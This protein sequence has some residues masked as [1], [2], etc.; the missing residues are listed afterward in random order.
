MQITS[1]APDDYKPS[2]ELLA[3]VNTSLLLQRPLL[4][5]GDPG[6]GK[7]E[8]A[9]FVAR[10][11]RASYPDKFKGTEAMRFNTKSVSQSTD[12]FYNYDA[13]AHFGD[14]EN[15]LKESFISFSSLGSALLCT[16]E[17]NKEWYKFCNYEA[18]VVN[19]NAG[20]GSV[21]LIDEIDKA[22]RD[23]PND[24][25]AELEKPPFKF[26][27]KELTGFEVVQSLAKPIVIII[28][29]NNEKGLPDAF[30][31]RC[32]FHHINFPDA[33]SLLEIVK[34]KL[35][36]ENPYFETAINIFLEMR[37]KKNINKP[38]AT[39]E[40]IDWITCLKENELLNTNLQNLKSAD[41]AYRKKITATLGII[42][43][44]KTD[45]ETL[46]K[47]IEGS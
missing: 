13:V 19:K 26:G 21:V 46:R 27:I 33:A 42:A 22:P 47:E 32:V 7:T 15:R 37:N 44:T 11:L 14:K 24:L 35:Q 28:T 23:F 16:L 1:I 20:F 4:L 34:T 31:R 8:C 6:T 18:A 3:A 10:Q 25:L 5:S 12:L 9:N 45:F 2:D 30:L 41:A 40:L 17:V 29:S 43:K 38:P 36:T 39:S